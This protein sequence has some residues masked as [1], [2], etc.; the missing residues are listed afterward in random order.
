MQVKDHITK[1]AKKGK[2]PSEIGV[3]LRDQH[4][5]AQVRAWLQT[6]WRPGGAACHCGA[7]QSAQPFRASIGTRVCSR[8]MQQSRTC[9]TDGLQ[10]LCLNVHVCMLPPCQ[11]GAVTGSKVLRIM[12]GLGLAPDIPEDLYHLIKKAVR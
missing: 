4:G 8:G 6:R 9:S 1:L 12:K 7:Y 11:V 5:I 10:G 2:T 3:F